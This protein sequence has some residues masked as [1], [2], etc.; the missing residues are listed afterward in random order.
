LA[1]TPIL[2]RDCRSWLRRKQVRFWEPG[3]ATR[4]F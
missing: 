1:V 3:G 2:R 4:A